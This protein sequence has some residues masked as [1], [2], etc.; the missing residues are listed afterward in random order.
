MGT[1]QAPGK[2]AEH[3]VVV[4][5]A[6]DGDTLRLRDGRSVRLVGI[7]APEID[8]EKGNHQHMALEAS[9]FLSKLTNG[10]R[11]RLE[12]DQSDHDRYGRILAYAFDSNGQMLNQLIVANGLAHVLYLPPDVKAHEIL[13]GAQRQAMTNKQGKWHNFTGEQGAFVGNARSKRFHRPGCPSARQITSKSKV[14]FETEREAFWAG[15]APCRR[16]LSWQKKA[17]VPSRYLSSILFLSINEKRSTLP[18]CSLILPEV[19]PPIDP[20]PHHNG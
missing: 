17:E 11:I 2:Q 1:F 19:F 13:L 15:Y 16:C 5:K 18:V 6:V 14:L 10:K 9:R 4:Q 20:G 8:H 3:W 12:K 7:D